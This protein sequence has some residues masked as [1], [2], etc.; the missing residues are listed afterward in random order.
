MTAQKYHLERNFQDLHFNY[1]YSF[2]IFD[3]IYNLRI[4]SVS[5]K[6]KKSAPTVLKLPLFG[7][8]WSRL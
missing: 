6:V 7:K 5:L 8:P 1:F 3:L 2:F 4:S